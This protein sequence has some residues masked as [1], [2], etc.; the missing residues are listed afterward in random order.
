[1]RRAKN[2]LGVL[3][4]GSDNPDS[5][6]PA[7]TSIGIALCPMDATDRNALLSHAK[8]E[9]RGTYRFFEASMGAAVRDRRL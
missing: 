2:I 9:G 3:Q 8:N 5:D 7:S 4:A 1:M 6:P